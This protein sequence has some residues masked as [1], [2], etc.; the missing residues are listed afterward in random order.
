MIPLPG[1]VFLLPMK[2]LLLAL[3]CAAP[4]LARAASILDDLD[5]AQRAELERGG[6]VVRMEE[7]AGKP[8]PRVRLYE[9][10]AA[11]PEEVAAV[12]FDYRNAKAYV[13]KVVKSDIS[14]RVSPCVIEVDYGIDV[15]LLPDEFYTAR[16]SLTADPDGSYCVSWRLVRALQTEDSE[17]N[18]RIETLGEGSAIR[19]TNL[20]TPGSSMAGLLRIP[21]IDQ[22]KDTVRAIA[23]H[24]EEVKRTQPA[25]LKQKVGFLREAIKGE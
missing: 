4:A 17:G 12:F 19:Y 1:W 14:L 25:E 24:V 21:A 10:V 11:T 3:L 15:P 2:A 8:W 7:V 16:N 23:R 6:Q 20:V 18:L 13:P 9:K 22:M 5:P